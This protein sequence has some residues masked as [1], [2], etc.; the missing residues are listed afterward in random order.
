VCE[1]RIYRRGLWKRFHDKSPREVSRYVAN[2]HRIVS[3]TV[4]HIRNSG[5]TVIEVNNGSDEVGVSELELRS[6]LAS[7]LALGSEMQRFELP[8]LEQIV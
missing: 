1:Q 7:I 6:K 4:D 8:G 2:S 5:W 3:L